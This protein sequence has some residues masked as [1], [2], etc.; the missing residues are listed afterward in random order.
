MK[1]K[2]IVHS[3]RIVIQTNFYGEKKSKFSVVS[4]REKVVF[5]N[6]EIVFKEWQS[7]P[8]FQHKENTSVA[9]ENLEKQLSFRKQ[10]QSS[11]DCRSNRGN[12]INRVKMV[13]AKLFAKIVN[14]KT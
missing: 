3:E 9:L 14:F 4:G 10:S 11:K 7:W 6:D 2:T 12:F 1:E 8:Q 13:W 5:V